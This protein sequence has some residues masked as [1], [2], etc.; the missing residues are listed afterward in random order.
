MV[1]D[2]KVTEDEGSAKSAAVVLQQRP[3]LMKM[4]RLTERSDPVDKCGAL[5][6]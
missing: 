6:A 2:T 3:W 1:M 4:H 5:L